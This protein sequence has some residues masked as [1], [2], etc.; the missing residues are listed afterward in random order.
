MW[1]AASG[2]K[3]CLHQSPPAPTFF[4]LVVGTGRCSSLIHSVSIAEHTVFD[5]DCAHW[6][7]LALLECALV[8]VG[9]VGTLY[10]ELK[11]K[12]MGKGKMLSLAF[13]AYMFY[14]EHTNLPCV[15]FC[16]CGPAA[17]FSRFFFFLFSP[18]LQD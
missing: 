18:T 10:I 13:W 5:T 12:H 2:R 17:T 4:I 6:N 14:L 7:L 8:N 3:T 16:A 15:Q 9:G 1:V 11:P